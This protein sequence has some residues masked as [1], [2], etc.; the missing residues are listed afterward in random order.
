MLMAL[1]SVEVIF[2]GTAFLIPVLVITR[3]SARSPRNPFVSTTV[4]M[5]EGANV[6]RIAIAPMAL[7]SVLKNFAGT[8]FLI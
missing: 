8:A 5:K 3:A 1:A 4:V 2:A 7:A 6:S